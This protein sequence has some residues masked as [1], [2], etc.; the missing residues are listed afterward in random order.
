MLEKFAVKQIFSYD[1][2]YIIYRKKIMK[3]F[4]K[5]KFGISIVAIIVIV[6]G[7]IT[8]SKLK[9]GVAHTF[10]E[11]KKGAISQEVIVTGKITPVDELDLAFERTGRISRVGADAGDEVQ[12][13]EILIELDSSE[14]RASLG[15]AQANAKA[16]KAKLD[17]LVRGTRPENIQIAKTDLLKAEQDLANEYSSVTQILNDA[18][19]KTDDAVRNQLNALFT[20]GDGITPQLTFST[21]DS[22][23]QIDVQSGRITA[24]TEL[25]AWKSELA[26][27]ASQSPT[28]KLEA[29][30]TRALLHLEKILA[31]LNRT[32]DAIVSSQLPVANTYKTNVTAA[33]S[34]VN[35]AI[36]DVN[37][38]IQ[39]IA[40]EKIAVDQAK[41]EIS[42]QLAGS[43][44]EDTHAQEAQLAQAEASVAVAQAR[45]N[46]T[47]L[48]SPIAGV[49]SKMDGKIGEVISANTIIASVISK[50]K[51]QIDANIPEIDIGKI[52]LGDNVSITFD[53]FPE[54]MFS[55]KVIKIDPA[56]TIIDGVVNFKT[57]IGLDNV[58]ER[59]K[60]GLTANLSIETDR[61]NDVLILPQEALM[62]KK[63]GTFVQKYE[64]GALK[65]YPVAVGLRDKN[66][67]VEIISGVTLGE[68][69]V[70]I[71]RKSAP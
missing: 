13:G 71:G 70:N 43:T 11:A 20:N 50:D 30:T 12:P 8:I 47:I 57:V 49:V 4:F 62:E 41:N 44:A 16:Q 64:N 32:M 10:I 29:A 38:K 17:E 21:S 66:G 18:Y 39:N 33:R 34:A 2:I 35:T 24:G 52:S 27:L 48:R 68:N 23:A 65:E 9:G 22:Q 3:T 36:S 46:Q 7:G 56:E 53:A 45:V 63:Q 42:L 55:G 54:E 28:D 5:S 51:F 67:S 14:L 69:V 60:S 15:E 59:V 37:G 40:S 61:K 58:D 25:N 19:A 26:A 31:F 6:A 1:Y